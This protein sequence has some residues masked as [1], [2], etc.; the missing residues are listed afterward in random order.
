MSTPE[1]KIILGDQL[2][3]MGEVYLKNHDPLSACASSTANLEGHEVKVIIMSIEMWDKVSQLL[4]I[5]HQG[6]VDAS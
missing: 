6:T 3:R 2:H 4:S 1:E 5:Q